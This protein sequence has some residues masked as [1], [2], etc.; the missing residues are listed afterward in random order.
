[1]DVTGEEQTPGQAPAGEL[2]ARNIRRIREGQRLTY[3]EL[4]ERL[5]GVGQ[6]IPVLG[7]RRIERLERSVGVVELL[8]LAYVLG[9]PPVDLL[10]PAD[11]QDE[12][13]DVTPRVTEPAAAV[14]DWIGGGFL[15]V[16]ANEYE[17]ARA[18]QWVPRKRA[19]ALA[20]EWW[21]PARQSEQVRQINRSEGL[22]DQEGEEVDG[23]PDQED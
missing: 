9:V 22:L 11:A 1:V 14:R 6:S 7:L 5:A 20:R 8:A 17:L 13:Y 16:P 23:R 4:A 18:I 10:V 3:V 15:R 19:Q 2:L 21:T 12:P